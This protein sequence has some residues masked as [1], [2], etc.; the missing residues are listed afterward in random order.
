MLLFYQVAASLDP[1]GRGST[2]TVVYRSKLALVLPINWHKDKTVSIF[3]L[4]LS[5]LL[6]YLTFASENLA[7]L[8]ISFKPRRTILAFVPISC[9]RAVHAGKTWEVI[10]RTFFTKLSFV[11]FNT[12]A[13][14][15]WEVLAFRWYSYITFLRALMKENIG[16]IRCLNSDL[17]E[18]CLW[19][20]SLIL[21]RQWRE[22]LEKTS[23]TK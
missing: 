19:W 8:A 3:H 12:A 13:R 23:I 16:Y 10:T 6:W 17:S 15:V 9:G 7:F 2:F 4:H 5:Y 20:N 21:T 11:W 14:V 1:V 22:Y 18:L